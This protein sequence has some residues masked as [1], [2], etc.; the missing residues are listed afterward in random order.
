MVSSE[1]S[2]ELSM[3]ESCLS[4]LWRAFSRTVSGPGHS[5]YHCMMT[6]FAMSGDREKEQLIEPLRCTKSWTE[7]FLHLKLFNPPNN[8]IGWVLLLPS[9]FSE[10]LHREANN[11][12]R[13]PLPISSSRAKIQVRPSSCQLNAPNLRGLGI[14]WRHSDFIINQFALLVGRATPLQCLL[15]TWKIKKLLWMF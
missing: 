3:V 12:P 9:F 2:A 4:R 1:T 8:S 10:E 14:T 6:V 13:F 5:F 15:L 11:F 7:Y